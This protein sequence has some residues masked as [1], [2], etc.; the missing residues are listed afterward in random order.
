ME[1][2]IFQ[3]LTTDAFICELE[4][5]ATK[6]QGLYVDMDNAPERKYVKDKADGINQLLKKIDRKRIDSAKEYK[7]K[8]ESEANAIIER[9]KSANE[10]F[11]LLIDG[12]K[13]ERAKILDAE[14]ARKQ[15]ILDA[16]EYENDHEMGL[17]INKTYEFDKSE[18]LRIQTERDDQIRKQ[19][20]IDAEACQKRLAEVAEH[21]RV[22]EENARLANKEHCA[23]INNEVLNS[24][25]ERFNFNHTIAK[26]L[27]VF[28]AKNNVPHLTIN[29]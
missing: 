1:I 28:I 4:E 20:T 10:P 13:A 17:L 23:L 15:A 27:V 12:Y 8:V 22:H 7:V 21:H 2:T 9:L 29:Y 25:V 11:T 26:E 5:E 18:E 14:K 24:L 16:A 3:E 6:Y 19:A